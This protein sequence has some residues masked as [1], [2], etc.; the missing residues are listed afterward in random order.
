MDG[1]L[2]ECDSSPW[3]VRGIDEKDPL[4]VKNSGRSSPL[5]EPGRRAIS[6]NAPR[7]RWQSWHPRHPVISNLQVA[8][9]PTGSESPPLRHHKINNLQRMHKA[10]LIAILIE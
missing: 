1:T 8:H 3:P 6:G 4:H 5:G 10:T 2:M 9:A 7:Q